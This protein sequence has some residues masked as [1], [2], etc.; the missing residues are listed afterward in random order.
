MSQ[1]SEVKAGAVVIIAA[2]VLILVYIFVWGPGRLGRSWDLRVIF[3]DAQGLTGGEP[4]RISGV[5]IGVVK[6]VSLNGNHEAL[7]TLS[8]RN[9]ITLYKNYTFTI[10]TGALVPE[11]YVEVHP[12]EVGGDT[13]ELTSESVARGLT[14]PGLQDIVVAAHDL[15]GQLEQTTA[16]VN[17]L[18]GDPEIAK[19]TKAMVQQLDIASAQA[20]QMMTTLNALSRNSSP[21][22]SQAV[23]RL[24]QAS[25][26]A[27]KAI[28]AI[29]QQLKNSSAPEDLESAVKAANESLQNAREITASLKQLLG[30]QEVQGDFRAS[31]ANVKSM[32]DQLLEASKNIKDITGDVKAGSPHIKSIA[33]KTDALLG[34]ANKLKERFKPPKVDARFDFREYPKTHQTS[35]DANFDLLFGGGRSSFRIGVSDIGEK[36]DV[37]LQQGKTR[38]GKTLRYGLVRSKLGLGGDL[39]LGPRA[40]LSLDIL[41]PNDLRADV[42]GEIGLSDSTGLI[43]GVRDVWGKD[44]NF[45]GARFGR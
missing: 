16:S 20:A 5:Q 31:M 25:S 2:I 18:I 39:I 28:C 32:S 11:R 8:I 42:T 35:A 37:N 41:D 12:A 45:V 26:E 36:N 44:L 14:T 24:S 13:K 29:A 1:R 27:S 22:I 30:D 10:A 21:E 43:F 6:E 4:V 40:Q 7:V 19:S 34:D 33:E 17:Q 23:T 15:L 9:D 3:P 38:G